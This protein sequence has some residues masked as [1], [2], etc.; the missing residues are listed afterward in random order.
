M[1]GAAKISCLEK[2]T[3]EEMEA[4]L[5]DFDPIEVMAQY[6]SFYISIYRLIYLSF[7]F[8]LKIRFLVEFSLTLPQ[9]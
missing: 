9:N 7:A 3:E 5:N 6:F 4:I 2:I 8:S 1:K